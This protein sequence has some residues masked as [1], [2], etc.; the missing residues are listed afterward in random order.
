MVSQYQFNGNET[1]RDFIYDTIVEDYIIKARNIEMTT[2]WEVIIEV[3][4]CVAE[5][6]KTALHKANISFSVKA[7]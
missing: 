7:I 3:N 4:E 6:V 2:A 1:M 5:I